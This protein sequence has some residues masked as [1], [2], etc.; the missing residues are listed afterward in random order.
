M[1]KKEKRSQPEENNEEKEKRQP[2][3]L[4]KTFDL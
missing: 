2:E 3:R 1:G 4:Q